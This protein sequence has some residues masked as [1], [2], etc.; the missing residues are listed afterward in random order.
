M[1]DAQKIALVKLEV[2]RVQRLPAS[3][4]YA[5]HRLKVLNKMLELLSK[6][7]SDAEAAELEALFAKFAL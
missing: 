3:S 7:R 1:D 4:A 5:I 6:A 2:E